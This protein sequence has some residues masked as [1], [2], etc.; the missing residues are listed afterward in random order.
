MADHESVEETAHLLR[1]S[2]R[3][4]T[5]QTRASLREISSPGPP[6]EISI[7][8]SQPLLPSYDFTSDLSIQGEEGNE[9]ISS[10]SSESDLN[11]DLKSTLISQKPACSTYSI[12]DTFSDDDVRDIINF[13]RDK[14]RGSFKTLLRTIARYPERHHGCVKSLEET[15]L[16]NENKLLTPKRI[17]K[18]LD[19]RDWKP[20][21]TLLKRQA[22]KFGA[23]VVG[24]FDV[25]PN[26]Q[27]DG[28]NNSTQLLINR[29]TTPGLAEQYAPRLF[30]VL[31]W[32]TQP[33][34]S[35]SSTLR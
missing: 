20:V 34:R 30:D 26:D 22:R 9:I 32:I 10:N 29:V 33:V 16:Y 8:N 25:R 14:K 27:T 23:Q 5:L 7:G 35:D 2:K 15:I 21:K 11:F 28:E 4:R 31:Q 3:P 12:K 17:V 18:I 6:S 19:E 13:L 24:Q 1:R